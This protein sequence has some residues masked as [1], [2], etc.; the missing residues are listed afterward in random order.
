MIVCHHTCIFRH[1]VACCESIIYLDFLKGI[2]SSDVIENLEVFYNYWICHSRQ[3]LTLVKKKTFNAI[4][5]ARRRN[6]WRLLQ[7]R[8][9]QK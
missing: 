2:F 5:G 1:S 4:M 7:W 3:L 9:V 8:Q 6:R